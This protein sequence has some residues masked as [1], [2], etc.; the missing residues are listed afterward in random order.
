MT[1]LVADSGCS[2]TGGLAQV[3]RVGS[4]PA[5][6]S[7]TSCRACSRSVPILKIS[8]ID[9]S[10]GTD[11][12]RMTSSPGMTLSGSS[13]GTV[14]SCSTSA[15]DSPRQAVW[16]CTR[17]GA[18]SGNTSTGMWR[19]CSTPKNIIPAASATAM[20]RNRR[21]DP[22]IQRMVACLL[23][24]DPELGAQELGSANGHDPCAR[25][26]A[27]FE[28]RQVPADV[29]DADPLPDEGQGRGAGVRPGVAVLVVK[30]GRVGD[31]TGG[32][33]G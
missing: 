16:T 32:G 11:W 26:R 21:L 5:M 29:V 24:A 7:W 22:T 33:L 17:G 10:W 13:S 2:M 25:G 4:T 20:N 19:S 27:R 3:G 15:A 8:S 28:D 6:R 23:A 31:G 12:E 1:R 14:T 18:N 9:D 30:H